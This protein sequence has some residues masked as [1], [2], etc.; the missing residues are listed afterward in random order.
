[1]NNFPRK[2]EQRSGFPPLREIITPCQITFVGE[3]TSLADDELE[4]RMRRLFAQCKHVRRAYLV[5]ASFGEPPVCSVILC[6][7]HVE[8]IEETLQRGFQHMFGEISRGHNFYDH[9]LIGEE[10][11]RELTKV[12][13]PFYEAA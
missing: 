11:E 9:M 3:Q 4:E 10:Q 12:C 6:E 5:Q 13:K 1:M 2:H 7:R 8:H